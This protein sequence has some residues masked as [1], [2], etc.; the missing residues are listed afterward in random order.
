MLKHSL[1]AV[2]VILLAACGSS[3]KATGDADDD[4]GTD[5][6]G[7]TSG[8]VP[9]DSI[10]AD[11]ADVP[12]PDVTPEVP[13]TCGD[14]ETD[15]GEECDDGNDVDG[16]GCNSDCTYS[17]HG[18]E[19]CADGDM[20]TSDVCTE[21]HVC[22]NNDLDCSDDDPC[23]TDWCDAGEGCVNSPLPDWY[24]DSDGDDYGDPHDHRCQEE[25]PE[26]YVDN[27]DDCCDSIEAVNPG[28]TSFFAESY[29][30]GGLTRSFDYNC[31]RTEEQRWTALGSCAMG[32]DGAC[33]GTVGWRGSSVPACGASH[34]WMGT[35]T[36]GGTGS[37][38]VSAGT[39][40]VQECR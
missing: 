24:R 37:T 34:D 38:C 14:G 15:T 6:P 36:S 23:T 7:D 16:D 19:D 18:A 29:D 17:C 4:T 9:T 8:E 1:I 22:V 40:R 11:G 39:T 35:C 2:L 30:C 31:D 28:Q 21:A 26:G 3:V 13:E 12:L 10:G 33:H 20:C 25:K 32:T 5:G 27:D